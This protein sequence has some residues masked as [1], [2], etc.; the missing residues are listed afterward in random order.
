MLVYFPWRWLIAKLPV[1]SFVPAAPHPR[2]PSILRRLT[3]P[4]AS[5][6]PSA[7]MHPGSSGM[8]GAANFVLTY[9]VDLAESRSINNTY[10]PCFCWPLIGEPRA[11]P[12]KHRR[13]RSVRKAWDQRRS[14]VRYHAD[15]PCWHYFRIALHCRFKIPHHCWIL[16]RHNRKVLM[17]RGRVNSLLKI[18][19][20]HLTIR[21]DN[22]EV[23]QVLR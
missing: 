21:L 10:V 23:K 20:Q 19:Q 9:V 13:L 8:V 22:Y 7:A 14:W 3:M 1:P 15:E 6:L 12:H 11:W 5:L 16:N 17:A 4:K 18:L 2:A